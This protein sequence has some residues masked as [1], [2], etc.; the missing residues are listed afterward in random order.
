MSCE[1]TFWNRYTRP[2]LS[3]LIQFIDRLLMKPS[4]YT[5]FI[6]MNQNVMNRFTIF[7]VHIFFSLSSYL[8]LILIENLFTYF[9]GEYQCPVL[10]KVFTEFT[11][12]I[13]VKT[14]GNVFSYEVCF[15]LID[16]TSILPSYVIP[17]PYVAC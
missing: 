7:L 11:H 4:I 14:T 9:A 8:I 2:F 12:I 1:T 17:N 6:D 10:N 16:C 3:T 15:L 13:A 5:I